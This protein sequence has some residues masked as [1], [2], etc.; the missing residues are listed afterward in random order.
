MKELHKRSRNPKFKKKYKV[1]NWKEYEQSLCNRGSLTVWISPSV[2]RTW[3]PKASNN[4][5]RQHQFSDQAIQT[6]L[7]LRLVFHLPLRQTEGF[8]ASIFQLMKLNLPVPDHTTLSRRGRTLKPKISVQQPD[9]KPL[10]IIVDSTGLS[11]HGEGPWSSGTK[12]R[13]GWRKLHI[14]ID[15]EGQIRSSCVSKWYTQD[16]QRAAHLLKQ[17]KDPIASFTGDKGY[18]QGSVYNHV[19]HHTEDAQI[20]IHPRSNAVLSEKGKWNQ[21]DRHVQKILD[22][23][24]HKWRTESGYYQQS[25]VENTFYRY[26]T[27]IGRKLHARTEESREVEALL[28]CMV[29]NRFTELGRCQSELVA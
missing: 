3:K 16:S 17:I 18:D 15:S 1:T 14:S 21:R 4:R 29:L 11:I 8:I 25:K 6:I 2:I 23:G 13:R 28:G 9:N 22:E 7:S 20:I 10:H 12:R 27:I 26:K 5:G 19:L 24:V